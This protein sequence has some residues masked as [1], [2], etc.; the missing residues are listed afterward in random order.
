MPQL[1]P[2]GHRLNGKGSRWLPKWRRL[3]I[4]LRDRFTCCYC[5]RDLHAAAPR[6]LTLDH[7]I[8][9]CDGGTHA[10]ANLVTACLS[11]N[12]R[13]QHTPWRRYATGGAVDHILR[14]RRRALPVVTAK[15]IL[16]G[17]LTK[18]QVLAERGAPCPM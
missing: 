17:S 12:S 10:N 14:V 5:G 2:N 16:A 13:R 4:Y 1:K 3:A 8:P 7:L 9:Q 6:E 18:E 11:C 15:A